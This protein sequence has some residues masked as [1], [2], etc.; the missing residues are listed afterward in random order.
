MRPVLAGDVFALAHVIEELPVQERFK[1]CA[2]LI[3]ETDFADKYRKQFGVLH[4]VW[5][6]GILMGRVG[7]LERWQGAAPSFQSPEFCASVVTALDAVTLWRDLKSRRSGQAILPIRCENSEL[8]PSIPALP[9]H[10]R[11]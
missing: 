2:I 6:N 3:E 1:T 10:S 8:S 4:P 11:N 9:L 7:Q 5:G